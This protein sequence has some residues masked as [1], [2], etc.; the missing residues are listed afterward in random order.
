MKIIK[1]LF[2]IVLLLLAV[3]KAGKQIF[4]STTRNLESNI[5][6]VSMSNLDREWAL[7]L[8]NAAHPLEETEEIELASMPGGEQVDKRIKPT[9][10]WMFIAMKEEGLHPYLRSGYRTHEKQAAY[11]EEKVRELIDVGYSRESAV[12]DAQY[13]VA[14]P[15][16][17][18]H[19]LGLAA[20]INDEIDNQATFD[21]LAIHAHEYG[22][23]QRYPADKISITV[24][25][26]EPWHYRYV[27]IDVAS[28]IYEKNLCLEEYL[29]SKEID[30]ND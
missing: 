24:V 14:R 4:M 20:D 7:T 29:E 16:T 23:I 30:I 10:D 1:R 19:E 22:Y 2:V 12:V 17:S 6:E 11:F 8:V 3:V 27:G 15:G 18:E 13:S 9:L 26:A 5:L 25:S 21:W 28:V